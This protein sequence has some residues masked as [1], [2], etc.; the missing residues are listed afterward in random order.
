MKRIAEAYGEAV[1]CARASYRKRFPA[2]R[3]Y[4][5]FDCPAEWLPDVVRA[6][7]AEIERLDRRGE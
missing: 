6:V 7:A 1:E 2:M 4:P 5:Y 3:Q